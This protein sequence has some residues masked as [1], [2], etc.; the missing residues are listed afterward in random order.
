MTERLAELMDLAV[1]R[2]GDREGITIQ[3]PGLGYAMALT[4]RELRHLVTVEVTEQSGGLL[5][6][7]PVCRLP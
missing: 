2:V 4:P 6:G 5:R 3:V 1:Q 7:W